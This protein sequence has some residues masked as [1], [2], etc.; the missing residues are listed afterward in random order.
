MVFAT[1]GRDIRFFFIIRIPVNEG[2]VDLPV[3][4]IIRATHLPWWKGALFGSGIFPG[5]GAVE[6]E[7]K[8]GERFR[9]FNV[10]RKGWDEAMSALG[11]SATA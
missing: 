11:V 4:E 9:F 6:I 10:A 3:T 7:T 5:L 2:P 8:S 1:H